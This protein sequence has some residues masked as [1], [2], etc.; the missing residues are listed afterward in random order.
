MAD[1]TQLAE[2]LGRAINQSPQAANLRAAR[3]A[4]NAEP[5][6]AKLLKDYQA[7]ADKIAT[8]E[9][10]QKPIEVE[11]KRTLRQLQERLFALEPFKKFTA[12]QIE[13]VDLMRNV[14][15]SLRAR[16]ADTEGQ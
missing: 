6:I 4:L 3:K 5:E 16:L 11:D 13:Y 2:Q 1:I 15:E 14:N 8:L 9:E 7:Q 12:S 10:E